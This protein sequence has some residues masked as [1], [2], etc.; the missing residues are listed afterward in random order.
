M[1]STE[2]IANRFREII[3]NGIW[4]ANT[5]YKHQLADLDWEVTTKQVASLNTIAILAQHIHYYIS[6]INNVF[7]G[8]T[9]DIRDA[10]SFDFP[11]IQSQDDWEVF[12]SKFWND[13]EEFASLI[14]Q[15]PDEKLD[16]VFVDAKYGTYRRNIDAM[17]EHSYY[18]LGQIV[19]LKKMLLI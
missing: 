18:H 8:G 1:N 6:G 13:S 15:M 4:V 12:L 9:L 3:F 11:L 2:E 5:N 19:L 16:S 14:E 17:I 7:N 10:Y